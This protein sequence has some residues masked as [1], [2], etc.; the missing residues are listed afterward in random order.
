MRYLRWCFT[1]LVLLVVLCFSRIT[2]A[3]ETTAFDG[4]SHLELG[5]GNYGADGHTKAS[6]AMT[7]LMKIMDVSDARNYIDDLD[8]SGDGC[9]KPED[10]YGVLFWT[11][12]ELV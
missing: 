11:L 5:A 12:D 7:V 1:S 6:Q 9:Y 10:Q 2:F 4:W 3:H 8:E